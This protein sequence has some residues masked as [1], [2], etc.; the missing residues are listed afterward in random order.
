MSTMTDLHNNITPSV[1]IEPQ[2]LSGTTDVVGSI[3]D[4]KGYSA[5]EF[6]LITDAIAVGSLDAQLLIEE[7]DAS[8]LS[9]AAAVSDTFLIGTELLTAIS[10]TSDKVA[11]R[12]GLRITKRYARAT[13]TVT[14]NDGT[15]IVAAICI[16]GGNRYLP[17]S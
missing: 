12:I 17:E 4:T 6:V 5:C 11:K 1:A 2:A 16:L 8:N 14:A 13:L 9:D 3:I 7:G 15:D 10:E